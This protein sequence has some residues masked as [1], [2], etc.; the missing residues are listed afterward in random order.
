MARQLKSSL[1][2]VAEAAGVDLFGVSPAARLA[3]A[4]EGFRPTDYLPDVKSVVVL[5]RHFPEATA[6]QWRRGVYPYQY[7]GYAIVNKELGHAAFRLANALEDAGFLAL[8]FVPTVYPKEMDYRRQAAE[9]SHRHAA[10]AAGLGEFGYSGLVL[11]EKYGTRARFVT[12]LTTAELAPDAMRRRP[13]LCDR[14]DKCLAACPSGA[15]R[16]EFE[17]TTAIDGMAITYARVDKYRCHYCIMGFHPDTGGI[18]NEPL[19]DRAGRLTHGDMVRAIAKAY[20]KH[21]VDAIV[22]HEMQHAIDWVDYCGRCLHVCHPN[23]RGLR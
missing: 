16:K 19:P 7:Y 8:P 1:R 18:I 3:G 17:E 6:L 4:P 15:L 12:I 21:P 20:V 5:G 14:C 22:Q 10:V 23:P 11:T 13:S 2:R 9:F